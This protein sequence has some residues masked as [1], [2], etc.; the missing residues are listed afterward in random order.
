MSPSQKLIDDELAARA[1]ASASI[2]W[3]LSARETEVL[4]HLAEG[5][6]NKDIAAKLSCALR[7]VEAHVTSILQKAHCESRAQVV[8][9][10]WRGL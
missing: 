7:T 4:R 2:R 3:E 9:R 8:A 10:F 6:A 5:D 1:L